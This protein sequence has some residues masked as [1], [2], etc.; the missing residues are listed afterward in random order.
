MFRVCVLA[1]FAVEMYS[2]PSI[3][4]VIIMPLDFKILKTLNC[5]VIF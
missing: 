1:G 3:L 4:F 2:N 5:D